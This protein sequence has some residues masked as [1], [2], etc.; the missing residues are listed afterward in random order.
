MLSKIKERINRTIKNENGSVSVYFIIFMIF[1]LPFAIWI[2]VQLPVKYELGDEVTQMVQNTADSII[3]RLD[4]PAL[5]SGTLKIDEQEATTVA[6]SIIKESLNLDDNFDPSGK[7]VL[8]EH[9]PVYI[10]HIDDLSNLSVDPDTGA[11]VLPQDVGVYVY[12]IDNPSQPIQIEDVSP[13]DKTSV[14]V[15]AN[16]PVEDGGMFG[17]RNVIHRTGVSEAHIYTGENS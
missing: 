13:I 6:D 15:Q 17:M 10:Q 12:L 14:V 11:Y 3:S 7:G 2:G 9:I 8:K 4:Q 5:A 1:F 16:I